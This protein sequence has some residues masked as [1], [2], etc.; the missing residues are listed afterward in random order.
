MIAVRRFVAAC[1]ILCSTFLLAQ[2]ESSCFRRSVVVSVVTRDKSEVVVD[3]TALN[4]RGQFRG[5]PVRIVSAE[6]AN[7]L[8]RVVV[9]LDTSSSM[10]D[11]PYSLALLQRVA[12]SLI[13]N[14]P[15]NTSLALMTFS[16]RVNDRIGFN[17]LRTDLQAVVT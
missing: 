11:S 5:K 16:D 1:T 12:S 13:S 3:L 9:L 14:V 17:G 6:S 7:R 10:A 15:A 4:F 2:D 8:N